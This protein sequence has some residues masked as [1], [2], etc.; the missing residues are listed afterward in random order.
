M[1]AKIRTGTDTITGRIING[2]FFGDG[3]YRY[4]VLEGA[5][6]NTLLGTARAFGWTVELKIGGHV[7]Q[8]KAILQ[9]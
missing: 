3:D 9:G 8:H 2:A 4:S 6:Q 7:G 5:S 1:I